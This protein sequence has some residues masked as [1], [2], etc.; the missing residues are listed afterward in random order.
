MQN[1]GLQ[2]HYAMMLFTS[3]SDNVMCDSNATYMV[4]GD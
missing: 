1:S 3:L 4:E 2:D